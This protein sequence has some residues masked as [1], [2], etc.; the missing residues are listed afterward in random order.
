MPKVG[1]KPGTEVMVQSNHSRL[2]NCQLQLHFIW[3][4]LQQW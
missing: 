1:W 3:S 4:Q 2:I